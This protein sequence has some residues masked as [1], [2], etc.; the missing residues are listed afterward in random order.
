MNAD[1]KSP[2]VCVCVCTFKREK[3]LEKL[4]VALSLQI[5][6]GDFTYSVVVADNDRN[7]SARKIVERVSSLVE[8]D[9]VYCHEAVQNIAM[10][11]NRALRYARGNYVAF[12]D[13]DEVPPENWLATMLMTCRKYGAAGVLA[14]VRPYFENE[15]P[16]WLVKGKFCDRPEHTTGHIMRWRET[17][18]GNVL[19]EKRILEG[20]EEP[21]QVQFGSGGE[22]QD[23]FRRLIERGETFLWCNEGAVYELVP[24]DR[25][26]RSYM[27][28]RALLRG[29]NEK[30]LTGLS[31]VCKSLVALPVYSMVLPLLFLAGQ[32]IFMRYVIKICDHAGKVIGFAGIKIPGVECLRG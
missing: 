13:D 14:P 29:L 1:V 25:W 19:L 6:H 4:L 23:F 20:M 9:L 15:P 5:T 11:R 24:P 22:D 27:I 31:G 28:K 17:R 21:F 12:I 32:S 26:T 2:H 8:M 3:L 7:R 10:A 30:H 16:R 18:T